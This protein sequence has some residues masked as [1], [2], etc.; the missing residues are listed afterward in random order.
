M[1]FSF[2]AMGMMIILLYILYKHFLNMQNDCMLP[3]VLEISAER[4]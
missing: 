4:S 1:Y 3:V 2:H